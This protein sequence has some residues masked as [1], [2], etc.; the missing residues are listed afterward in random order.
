V[1]VDA[2]RLDRA[3]F[4]GSIDRLIWNTNRIAAR[5][6][7]IATERVLFVCQ[8]VLGAISQALVSRAIEPVPNFQR[9]RRRTQSAFAPE[10]LG[11]LFGETVSAGALEP[12]GYDDRALAPPH[13]D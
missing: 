1:R 8:G 4:P 7:P 5:S 13:A 9:E 12:N 10:H 6:M 3:R 11:D 2:L